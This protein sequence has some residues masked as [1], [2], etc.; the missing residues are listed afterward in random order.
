M[1]AM[2]VTSTR[3]SGPGKGEE[4]CHHGA[5]MDGTQ[6]VPSLLAHSGMLQEKSLRLGK[7]K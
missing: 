4:K 3:I 5:S 2:M 7:K 1:G 6:A